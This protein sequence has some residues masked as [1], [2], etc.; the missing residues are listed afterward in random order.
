M[1]NNPSFKE[2]HGYALKNKDPNSRTLLVWV[3]ELLPGYQGNAVAVEE[4]K[5]TNYITAE[6]RDET[7]N[8]IYPPDIR[9]GEDV[10]IAK[11][12]DSAQWYW[13][14]SGRSKDLRTTE[15]TTQGYA[16]NPEPHDTLT[17][18]DMYMQGVDTTEGK[19]NLFK[20][21]QKNEE[22][23]GWS[24]LV[25]TKAGTMTIADSSGCQIV[26]NPNVPE[27]ILTLPNLA[28][29]KLT[30][31]N[32]TLFAP[33]D[34]TISSKRQIVINSPIVTI[35]NNEGDSALA[36]NSKNMAVNASD[37]FV[38]NS[39]CSQLGGNVVVPES[40]VTGPVYSP[41][42]NNADVGQ[43]YQGV[44]TNP[45]AGSSS[46]PAN[47]PNTQGG[48]AITSDRNGTAWQDINASVNAVCDALQIIQNSCLGHPSISS[49]ISTARSKA[50][51]SKMNRTTGE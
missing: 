45:G 33:E 47:S 20:T 51:S 10:V 44:S 46:T 49:Q 38:V 9:K 41:N 22:P 19:V 32:A 3:P 27:I 24:F 2:Y 7:S 17:H 31:K 29:L 36:I 34:I 48:S 11:A 5:S 14:A 1:S 18:E 4:G 13:K 37:S 50:A 42:Y 6:W 21:S 16:A 23:F 39:K 8:T 40:L 25:D 28:F 12:I 26:V 43:T 35:E 15:Q 30:E